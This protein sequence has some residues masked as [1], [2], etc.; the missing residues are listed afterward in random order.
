MQLE[1]G[2]FNP[3]NADAVQ[4]GK[5]RGGASSTNKMV[6]VDGANPEGPKVKRAVKMGEAGGASSRRAFSPEEMAVFRAVWLA[7]SDGEP[8][9]NDRQ[10]SMFGLNMLRNPR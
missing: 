5:A 4:E 7:Q 2:I 3:K 8:P 9:M 6:P 10:L 1:R